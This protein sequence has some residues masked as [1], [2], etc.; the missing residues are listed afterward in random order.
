M[1]LLALWC[2]PRESK[3][4]HPDP[5]KPW[6][7]K[8]RLIPQKARNGIAGKRSP[9]VNILRTAKGASGKGSHQNSSKSVKT[10]TSK[11]RQKMCPKQVSQNNQEGGTAQGGGRKNEFVDAR[12]VQRAFRG[13]C[14]GF[15]YIRLKKQGIFTR[16]QTVLCI[17]ARLRCVW[18]RFPSGTP[19][20]QHPPYDYSGF[21]HFSTI[22]A[23][24][25]Y[26]PAP[27]QLGPCRTEN[28]TVLSSE[29]CK[30]M[31][32]AFLLEP[33]AAT[34]SCMLSTPPWQQAFT[35]LLPS[36]GAT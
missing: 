29:W 22:L 24:S 12:Q 5:R 18:M 11:N 2:K 6:R 15:F 30:L 28:P 20:L 26:F 31:V 34:P 27:S 23:R 25:T 19:P 32:H 1:L 10:R 8:I 17:H 14:S 33:S 36:K 35:S 9:Q 16:S 7:R 13:T 4:P 3:A 21:L